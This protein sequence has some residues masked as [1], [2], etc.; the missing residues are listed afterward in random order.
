M[1]VDSS[2]NKKEI[3]FYPT[4][5]RAKLAFKLGEVD[6]LEDLLDPSPFETWETVNV[7]SEVNRN[8][9]VAVFFNN[10]DP[11][12]SS[13]ELRQA[14]SY[15]VD[16]SV[17]PAERALGP[18]SPDSW[19][20]NPQIKTYDYNKER[21]IELIKKMDKNSLKNLDLKLVTTPALLPIAETIEKYWEEVGITTTVQVSSV[22]PSEFQA[23]LVIYDIPKDPDQYI[24]WHSSQDETNIA[25]YTKNQR[26]DKLLEDGRLEMREEERKKIYFDFQRFLLEDAPA[27]FL[28][29]PYSYTI[30]RK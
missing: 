14:L 22:V 19:A 4:Q 15:A 28:Y 7:I 27:I 13:K 11:I 21:A 29:H 20:Y 25:R 24:T 10:E 9:Y 6:T 26:I 1:L 8:R 23:F 2:D 12:L 30:E 17:M 5:D 16:K 3:H 18:I